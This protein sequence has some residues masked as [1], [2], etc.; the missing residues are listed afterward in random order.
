MQLEVPNTCFGDGKLEL[1]KR[2]MMLLSPVIS[3]EQ[4]SNFGKNVSVASWRLASKISF[5]VPELTVP[6][7]AV[8]V[9]TGMFWCLGGSFVEVEQTICKYALYG[10][11]QNGSTHGCYARKSEGHFEPQTIILHAWLCKLAYPGPS[12]DAGNKTEHIGG[13]LV[14]L[15]RG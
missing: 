5:Q 7:Q 14:N 4:S 3:I 9:G 8:L 10:C 1:R 2:C 12:A 15:S 6:H 11:C 13:I